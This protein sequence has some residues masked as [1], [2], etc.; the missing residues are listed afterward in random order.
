MLMNA[1]PLALYAIACVRYA[2][3]FASRT[4]N[5]SRAASTWLIM[6]AFAHTFVIGMETMR[7]GHV[8]I[9]GAT[10]AISTFVWLLA[11]S[12]LYIE[13]TTSERSMGVFILPLLAALQVIPAVAARRSRSD[14]RR[15]R[16]GA[17]RRARVVA[18]VRLCQL[19]AGLRAWASPTFCSSR[20]SR[21]KTWGISTPGCRRCRSSTR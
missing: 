20:K 5:T 3:Q 13:F 6:A 19:R 21:R 17:V 1:V 14:R 4:L 10:S 16:G 9:A 12:Y 15:A 18:A 11:L 2:M 8:P 7:V